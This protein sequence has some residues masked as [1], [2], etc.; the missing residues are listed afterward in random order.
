MSVILKLMGYCVKLKVISF[1]C[2]FPDF[3]HT[4]LS[5]SRGG[6]TGNNCSVLWQYSVRG[7]EICNNIVNWHWPLKNNILARVCAFR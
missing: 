3:F 4:T 6:K 7:R 5:L 1:I 2:S